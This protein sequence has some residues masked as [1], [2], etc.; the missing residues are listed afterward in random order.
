MKSKGLLKE[1]DGD[2]A[3]LHLLEDSWS[4]ADGKAG[5]EQHLHVKLHGSFGGRDFF[6]GVAEIRVWTSVSVQEGVTHCRLPEQ[7]QGT[8]SCA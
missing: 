6:H 5:E 3:S 4:T 1:G 2:T 8:P 7:K